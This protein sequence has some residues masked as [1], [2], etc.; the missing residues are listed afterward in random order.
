MVYFD[1]TIFKNVINSELVNNYGN[2]LS[3]TIAMIKQNFDGSI[4]YHE[5]KLK[6][7]DENILNQI[8][9]T[10]NKY[11]EYFDNF[12]IDNAFI[13]VIMLSKK[14]N[15][16]IDT[17]KPWNLKD[18]LERL[19]V[20]LNSLLQGIYAI[21]TMLSVVIPNKSNEAKVQ[22]GN[23]ELDLNLITDFKKFDKIIVTKG[24]TLFE[25]IK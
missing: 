12:K 24:P 2:L 21:T 19:E 8:E 6:D 10:K 9:N 5:S 14:L 18:N 15:V 16:Y 3:R 22:L 7:I 20:I 11:I 13:E 4:K 17:T 1:K 23:I 25:R